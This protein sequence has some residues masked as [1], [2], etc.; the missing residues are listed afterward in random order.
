MCVHIIV[1]LA[2]RPLSCGESSK[3][4][5]LLWWTALCNTQYCTRL[6]SLETCVAPTAPAH[7]IIIYPAKHY[8]CINSGRDG[9]SCRLRAVS[10]RYTYTMPR[11]SR[12]LVPTYAVNTN[13]IP[14]VCSVCHCILGESRYGF[15]FLSV[16]THI[17]LLTVIYAHFTFV[18]RA[19]CTVHNVIL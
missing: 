7:V 8:R 19:C 16:S 15:F 5:L 12:S 4:P 9:C 6:S 18:S 1:R 17:I 11:S 10:T 3:R 13:I 14:T 2:P